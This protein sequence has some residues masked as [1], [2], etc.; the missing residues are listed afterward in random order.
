MAN[1]LVAEFIGVKIFALEDTL[2]MEPFNWNLF[3]TQGSLSF[4]AGV[5]LWPFVFILTDIIN[6]YFGRKG[7]R[8]LSIMAASLIAYSFLMVFAAIHLAPDQGWWVGSNRENGVPDMQAAFVAIFGQS[9]WII[10]G[11][12][13]AFLVGQI[14]D[15]YVFFR[16]R[17]ITG[18]KRI[19]VRA[20]V[21]TFV[22][23]FVDSYIVLYV[24]F[25][26]PGKWSLPM[27][28]AIGTVN[29]IY[30]IFAAVLLIPVLG[31]VHAIIEKYLGTEL[32]AQLR[33][34]ASENL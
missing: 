30:K 12:L 3:G 8:F 27:F 29:Y 2:G 17:K 7:V 16:V 20:T 31:A 32:S 21:S 6:D 1:A 33:K 26:V 22:S 14:L 23:Q 19:W 11:S 18:D 5:L 15:A 13:V 10:V 9:N 28:F 34:E 25:V 4:T 24:A